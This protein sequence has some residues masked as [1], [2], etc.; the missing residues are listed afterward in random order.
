M[1]ATKLNKKKATL[2]KAGMLDTIY[3]YKPIK[4]SLKEL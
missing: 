3:E 4:K 1:D 2:K